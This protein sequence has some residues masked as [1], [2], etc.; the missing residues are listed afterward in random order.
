NGKEYHGVACR[1]VVN[2]RSYTCGFARV[3]VKAVKFTEPKTVDH[4]RLPSAGSEILKFDRHGSVR[5]GGRLIEGDEVDGIRSARFLLRVDLILRAIQLNRN[6]KVRYAGGR[7]EI[8]DV[9][10]GHRL[11]KTKFPDFCIPDQPDCLIF[12][13]LWKMHLC[14]SFRTVLNKG[15]GIHL[16]FIAFFGERIFKACS[17][18]VS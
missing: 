11:L 1:H 17:P 9:Y 10:R 3:R 16:P 15:K 18:V 14:P 2:R 6:I 5:N 7:T 4:L 13:V 8:I 12:Q